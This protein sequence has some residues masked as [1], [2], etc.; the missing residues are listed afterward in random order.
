MALQAVAAANALVG[1][2]TDCAAVAKRAAAMTSH[3]SNQIVIMCVLCAMPVKL[4]VHCSAAM[5]R[6]LF[7]PGRQLNGQQQA[8]RGMPLATGGHPSRLQSQRAASPAHRYSQINQSLVIQARPVR[9]LAVLHTRVCSS[10]A[11]RACCPVRIHALRRFNN[12]Y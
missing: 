9:V 6:C 8:S 12:A 2:N 1:L 11:A 3:Y 7:C 5:C 10:N 4:I